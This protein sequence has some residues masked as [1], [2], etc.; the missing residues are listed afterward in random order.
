VVLRDGRTGQPVGRP[1]ASPK[2]IHAL[3]FSPDGK[4]LAVGGVAGTFILDVPA[5]TLRHRL[6]EATCVCGLKWNADSRRLLVTARPGW[7]GVGA[8]LRVWDAHTGQPLGP[9]RSAGRGYLGVEAT[10]RAGA[11]DELVSCEAGESG[12][13]RLSPDGKEV[14]GQEATGPLR[15][16]QFSPDG[17]RMAASTSGTNVRQRDTRT[18]QT[19]GPVLR[20]PEPTQMIR[21][22]GDGRLLA[23][24]CL[25]DTVRLWDADTGWP[26]GPPLQHLDTPVGWAFRDRDRTL[27]SVTEAGIAHSWPVP[28]PIEDDPDRFETWLA[29]RGGLRL[30]GE[31]PVQVRLSE[32]QAACRTLEQRWPQPDPALAEVSD[33]LTPWHRQ[34]ALDAAAVGNDRG[35]LYHL[36]RLAALCP[37]EPAVLARSARVHARVAGRLPA[38]PARDREW[39]LAAD[40]L[41]RQPHWPGANHWARLVALEAVG[42]GADDEALWYLDRLA[43]RGGDWSV[44]ADRADLHGRRG[45]Q[46]LREA[47]RKRALAL[48]GDKERDFALKVADEGA[49][50]DRWAEVARL[51]NTAHQVDPA[52]LTSVERLALAHLKAGNRVRYVE[53]CRAALRNL[54]SRGDSSEVVAVLGLCGLAPAVV[55]NWQAPLERMERAVRGMEAAESRAS[56]DEKDRLRGL[57]REWL[58]TWAGLLHRAGRPADAVLRLHE[59]MRLAP[60]G[61]G[62]PVEW[63]WLALAHAALEKAPHT[64]ARRWLER[65]RAGLPKRDGEGLWQA[66]LLEVLVTEAAKALEGGR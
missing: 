55:E 42:R 28:Q 45:D 14:R 51:L 61:E 54:S 26:L 63:V 18:G 65:A 6:P 25:D 22:S 32:W 60:G 58:T 41:E 50:Q 30:Q 33:D 8:G 52:D 49:R 15:L 20:H 5:N 3:A 31:E 24:A 7:P 9:F 62:G 36:T 17:R 37:G 34:R 59:A 16:V 29:A 13:V 39:K 47:D 35:E 48:G 64:E 27:L 1:W 21:Y 43:A 46:A 10:W 19:V 11:D 38:G 66:V 12:L 53:L 57:R 56:G 2:L 40:V 4:L 44:F 23:V